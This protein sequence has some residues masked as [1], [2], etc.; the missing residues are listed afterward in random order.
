[1]DNAQDRAWGTNFAD[2]KGETLA[3][4]LATGRVLCDTKLPRMPDRNPTV[5]DD[6]VFMTS[7]DG[8]PDRLHRKNGSVVWKET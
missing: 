4:D 6:M 5:A 1:M 8:Y 2:G 7:F 3:L